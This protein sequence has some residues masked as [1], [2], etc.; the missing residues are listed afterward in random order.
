MKQLW[1]PLGISLILATAATGC[2]DSGWGDKAPFTAPPPP[3]TY[4]APAPTEPVAVPD[5]PKPAGNTDPVLVE[6]VFGRDT[7]PCEDPLCKEPSPKTQ[8]LGVVV[9]SLEY[10]DPNLVTETEGGLVATNVFEGLLMPTRQ[11]GL[12]YEQGV[13]T[14]YALSDD[15]RV[16]TFY[17][18]KNAK[19]SDGSPV[20]AHDFVYSWRRKASPELGTTAIEAIV[21]LKN[22]PKIMDGTIKDLTQLGVRAIDDYTLE[23]TLEAPTPW[24]TTYVATYHLFPVPK[25]VVELHGKFWTRPENI[26]SNGAYEL[27]V[28]KPRERLEMVK[29]ETYWDRDNVRI[30]RINVIETADQ[31]VEVNLF[32]T[33]GIQ[34]ARKGVPP[35][36]IAKEI[37][38]GSPDFFID[39][40]L[41]YYHYVFRQDRPPFDNVKVRK[42]FALAIDR[43]RLVELVTQGMEIPATGVVGPFF[44]D[45]MDY[46]TPD[47]IGFDIGEAKRLLAEAGYPNGE[48]LPSI[49]LIYN[50]M[51][52]H[53]LIAEYVARNLREN[54]G[55]D[56]T[57]ANMEFKS[58]LKA[59]R[60]GEFEMMRRGWCGSE[61]P[62][63]MLSIFESTSPR[64]VYAYKS[65]R[66][67]SLLKQARKPMPQLE[68]MK[69]LAQAEAQLLDD[70]VL[71]PI[72]HYTQSRLTKPVLRG[73]EVE[74][75]N[76]HP[77]KYMWWGDTQ[78]PPIAR[79]MPPVNHTKTAATPTPDPANTVV[80][81]DPATKDEPLKHI[82]GTD[83]Y[84][85]VGHSICNDASPADGFV[86]ADLF[87]IKSLDP[88]LVSETAGSMLVTNIFEGLINSPVR[89][90]MPW[91][92]GVA[93]RWEATA[94]QLIHTFYLRK[95]ARW[96]DGSPVTANDFIYGWRRKLDPA[97][98]SKSAAELNLIKGAEAFTSGK[99]RDPLSLGLRAIDDHTLEVTLERPTPFFFNK[100]AGG[101]FMP[102]PKQAI[103]AHG[104]KWTRPENIVT[105]GPFNLKVWREREFLR[106][107]RASTYWDVANVKIPGANLY[108]TNSSE[109]SFN[110]YR[111]GTLHW[112]RNAV[113]PN[114][115]TQ[116]LEAKR[117]DFFIDP[118]LCYYAYVFNVEKPPFD[119]VEVR[120]AF[121]MAI[122]KRAL[123]TH[124]TKALQTPAIGPVPSHFETTMG[125]PKPEGDG[126]DPATARRLLKDAGYEDISTLPPV[127]LLYNTS[128]GHKL[129]A[130]FVSRGWRENIG[131]KVETEN[132]DW[133]SMLDKIRKGDFQV[134]RFGWCGVEHPY[135]M[136]QTF[137][138]T[139][140]DNISNY[141]NP[142]FDAAVKTALELTDHTAA[143]QA[144]ANVEAILNRDAPAAALYYYTKAYLKRPVLRGLEPELT[145]T[146]LFKWMSWGDKK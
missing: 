82:Y 84:P 144:F 105:N 26:V 36:D 54:L 111:A 98:A 1:I 44:E 10:I 92:P 143:M 129:I 87:P 102:A 63:T 35:T 136:V 57:L 107:E 21:F 118:F 11:A 19:W 59:A 50:T 24:W 45:A 40:M 20:T 72:Y 3:A 112:G 96:S 9:G 93:E 77:V 104:D 78:E 67:D 113:G 134:T 100:L 68:R 13:A 109:Q 131:V 30:P 23:A 43:R 14:H 25:H 125:Y 22:A 16:Y 53:K 103:D 60:K 52:R 37:E 46:P 4:V 74:L 15:E 138:S 51:E 89:S 8:A 97:T 145:N 64:N 123:V 61:H 94:D 140:P 121:G 73:I 38:K 56:V 31:K 146:H 133:K 39:P 85:C 49:E 127:T 116:L 58:L 66:F 120:R 12:P 6:S 18:R 110:N 88:G 48:G 28:W 41:C 130:E 65:E 29:S 33:G 42:A 108:V 90:G 124:V 80:K 128:E 55:V 119:K 126:F 139:H 117:P 106:L 114:H 83:S 79:P 70:A 135:D 71:A 2:S 7:Y 132:R 27:K 101:H 81:T 99:N 47:G 86:G 95:D 17:L 115:V 142:E 75:G 5:G 76:E 32:R 141:A 122:D 62:Y 137:L 91:A 34:W 69:L